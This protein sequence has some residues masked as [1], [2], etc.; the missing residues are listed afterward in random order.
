MIDGMMPGENEHVKLTADSEDF[1]P[2]Q[3]WNC[4]REGALEEVKRSLGYVARE[5]GWI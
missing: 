1:N 5:K 4:Y 3:C 2:L